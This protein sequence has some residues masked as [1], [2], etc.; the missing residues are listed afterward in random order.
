MNDCLHIGFIVD[1]KDPLHW[2]VLEIHSVTSVLCIRDIALDITCRVL[3]RSRYKERALKADLDGKIVKLTFSK[4]Q[5]KC[6]FY[7]CL[8]K[9]CANH[10]EYLL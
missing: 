9:L 10:M 5:Y 8:E 6:R 3:R 2:F 4:Q 1:K 7:S